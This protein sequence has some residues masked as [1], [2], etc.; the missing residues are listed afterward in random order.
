M[1]Q[2]EL[3]AVPRAEVKSRQGLEWLICGQFPAN[4]A[5]ISLCRNAMLAI[6]EYEGIRLITP[7]D[8]LDKPRRRGKRH[9]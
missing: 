5:E 4:V 1:A 8:Y 7:A 9:E 3:C 2:G 6:G